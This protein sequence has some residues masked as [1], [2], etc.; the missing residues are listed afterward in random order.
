[1]HLLVFVCGARAILGIGGETR[2]V[3]GLVAGLVVEGASFQKRLLRRSLLLNQIL[4]MPL[5][6][7]LLPL[8]FLGFFD[9]FQIFCHFL[10]LKSGLLPHLLLLLLLVMLLNI[11]GLQLRLHLHFSGFG[12]GR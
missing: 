12:I 6:K 8:L 9:F 11:H 7:L 3:L 1:M 5:P 4:P 2:G 10:I